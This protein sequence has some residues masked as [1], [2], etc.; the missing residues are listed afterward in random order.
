[1]DLNSGGKGRGGD[2]DAGDAG[3]FLGFPS[4]NGDGSVKRP[5]RD[6]GT[7]KPDGTGTLKSLRIEPLDAVL[8]VKAGTAAKQDYKVFGQFVGEKGE[9][10]ITDRSVFYISDNVRLGAFANDGP[11]FASNT[12]EPYGGYATVVALAANPDG[13]ILT[14]S[15]SIVVKLKALL[16]DPRDDG[17]ATFDIPSDASTLLSGPKDT[18]RAP[19]LVYPNDGALL[20]PNLNRLAVHFLPG[21]DNELF[22]VR[23]ESRMLLLRYHM[24]CGT[25]VD[26]GCLF[27]LDQAGYQTLA[28]SNRGTEPVSVT[29][30]GTDDAGTGVGHSAKSQIQFAQDN[31]NGG[32]YYWSTSGDTAIMRFN[33]G[34]ANASPE[35]FLAPNQDG[36]GNECVG[37]HAISPDGRRVVASLSG[38]GAGEQVLVND[39]TVPKTDAMFLDRNGQAADDASNRLQFASFNPDG[40]EFVAVFGDTDAPE[41][42]TLWFH[43]G[44]TGT[45]IAG[46]EI[47]FDFEPD[48]PDWSSNGKK[49]LFTHVG[50]HQTSQRPFNCGID[51]I[52]SSADV[53]SAPKTVIPIVDG[54]GLSHYNPDFVTDDAFFVFSESQCDDPTADSGDECDGDA[55]P[56]ARTWAAVAKAAAT[57]VLLARAGAPG[58]MDAGETKLSDTFPRGAPFESTYL[59]KDQVLDG[60]VERLPVYWVTVASTRRIGLQN[61]AH[62]RQLWMFAVDPQMVLDGKDGSFPAFHLPFQDQDTDN[63]IAQWT[64]SIVSDDPPPPPPEPPPP[65]KAPPPPIPE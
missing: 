64:K 31:V 35:V 54:D 32:L 60:E 47:V 46:Q 50:I 38:Q 29:V 9:T 39:L 49:I 21:T 3:T 36:M 7:P 25:P 10:E 62:I 15:T 53:W 52:T 44:V 33:F 34:V 59:G 28:E 6:A 43:D 37:C 4:P 55:D 20:P 61:S 8:T 56:S 45:R 41:R 18:S 23:F 2:Q 26:G 58:V 12:K 24:R 48:H 5:L 63:H 11:T 65:P 13:S 51:M 40:S 57:P 17:S 16:K 42:N 30:R 14:V 22:E 27:E 19:E 1:M